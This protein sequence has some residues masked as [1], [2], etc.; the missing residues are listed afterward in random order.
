M[1]R[2]ARTKYN[3]I[4]TEA[5]LAQWACR[6]ETYQPTTDDLTSSVNRRPGSGD[7]ASNSNI[8]NERG[9]SRLAASRTQ[10]DESKTKVPSWSLCL[11]R[12]TATCVRKARDPTPRNKCV[13]HFPSRD[14]TFEGSSKAA[15]CQN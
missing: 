12:L 10:L 9:R 7:L 8:S 5:E 2:T 1:S 3:S 11:T 15:T 14:A 6:S 13:R 4:T